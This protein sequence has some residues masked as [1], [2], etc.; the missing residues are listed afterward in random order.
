M[1]V[2]GEPGVGKSRLAAEFVGRVGSRARVVRGACLSYG[3]GITFW[4]VA[5]I[6]RELAGIRD[7]HSAAEARE[8]VEPR[9]AQLI[10][11]AEGAATADQMMLAVASFL[12]AAAAER[13]LVVLVDDIHWAEP[14]LFDLLEALPRMVGEVPL[15]FCCLARPELLEARPEWPVSVRL[16]PLGE[17]EIDVLLASLGASA[18]VRARL[19]H[20]AAG[21]PLFAEEL[22]AWARENDLDSDALPTSLNALLG[23]RL[24]RLDAE[25]RD[26]LER[27][28]VEGELFHRGAVVELSDEKARPSVPDGLAK[29]SGRDMIRPAAASFAGE[30][31]FRFKHI[32]VREAAYR[33]TAKK[34]RASLHEH[35]ADW[36]ERL[37]GERV[38]EYQE[39]LG[40]HFEQAYRYR[41]EL[42]PVDDEARALAVRAGR[43]LAVAGRRALDR[44]DVFAAANLLGRANEL[45]P[46][47]SLER[48]ELMPHYAYAVH[49]TG[50]V[51]EGEAIKNELYERATALGERGLAAHARVGRGVFTDPN[52]D[53]DEARAIAEEGIEMFT[54]LGDEAGL[55]SANRWLANVCRV[56]GRQAEAT[57]WLERALVHANACGD[58]VTRRIVTQ[59]LAMVIE[60]GPMPA[61]DAIRRCEELRDANLDDRVLEAVI[62]RC[63]SALLAMAGR[64]DEAREYGRR[65]SRVLEEANMLTSSRVTQNIAAE[66]KALAGD[67]AGAERDME[68]MWL[69]FRD[70]LGGAPDRRG[71]SAAYELANLYCD[72]G[73]WDDAEE[74]H[75]FYRDAPDP[76]AVGTTANRL[77]G[78]GRLAAHRG[79]LGEAA[80]LAQRAVEI[81]EAPTC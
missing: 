75:A 35:F 81:A 49:E 43:H 16:E 57:E 9:I 67:R 73:R 13:P 69:A 60:N 61:G 39:I 55:A 28:A 46:A 22:L 52:V 62:T 80:T 12:A 27:G 14:A 4:A 74:C 29:L 79:E 59:S 23:A 17:G 50:R 53:L 20:A 38:G 15:L 33:A 19:A 40:Y 76:T 3:E 34:L 7:D 78:A 25:A 26:A 42:G 45:L 63:L 58:L 6:V 71:M 44:G 11:L 65:S 51:L 56:Q 21:N 31:A 47:D 64:F 68:A 30:I 72:D 18:E 54:E 37:V 5:Q 24:D 70:T 48:L 2:V 32:L 41:M 36:L 10:G 77:A 66:A 8:R 1:T